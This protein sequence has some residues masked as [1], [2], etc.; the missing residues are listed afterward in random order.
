MCRPMRVTRISTGDDGQSHFEDLEVPLG[1]GSDRLSDIV[2]LTG[3]IFRHT[4]AGSHLDYHP[5]PRRQF[6]VT[7]TGR[8]EVGCADGTSRVFGPGDVMLAD[9]LTGQ[10]HTSVQLGDEDRTS[11]FLVIDEGVDITSWRPA[12]DVS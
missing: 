3:V 10:G 8:V 4:R 2:P 11:L 1:P 5:A 6:V 7:L 9:D 12:A